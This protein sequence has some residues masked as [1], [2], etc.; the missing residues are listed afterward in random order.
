VKR[1][2]RLY[3]WT[4][5]CEGDKTEREGVSSIQEKETAECV[6]KRKKTLTKLP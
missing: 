3:C 4:G 5:G 1:A 2:D 6:I